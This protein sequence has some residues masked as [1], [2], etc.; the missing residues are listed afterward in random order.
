MPL[1]TCSLCNF[2]SMLKGDYKRHLKTNKHINNHNKYGVKTTKDHKKTTKDHKKTT[3]NGQKTW[4]FKCNF[5]DETYTTYAHKRRHENHYCKENPMIINDIIKIKDKQL[6]E[7]DKRIQKLEKKVEKLTNKIGNT[8]NI[9]NNIINNNIKINSY[10]EEDLSFITD[11]FKTEMLKIPYGA[12]PKM[13][14]TIHFNNEKPENKNII[15]PNISKNIL[16]IKN[17]EKW[18]HK[19]KDLI[20]YDMIDSKYLILDDHFDLIVNGEK[21]S[22]HNKKN[23]IKF[24]EQFDV[25]DKELFNNLKSDCELIMLNKREEQ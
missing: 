12:I 7:N 20:L 14:E 15:Y 18:Q 19:N 1:Y 3:K 10:G 5:C 2:S 17:G 8:T 9:Q 6:K 23:Y 4:E 21:L 13:I 16:K 25:G 11:A 22:S 24:R